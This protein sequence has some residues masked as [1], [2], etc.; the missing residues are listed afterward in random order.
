[1]AAKYEPLKRHRRATPNS[2]SEV[3]LSFQQINEII[4]DP[5]PQSAYTYREWWSNQSDTRNRPQAHAW[6]AAGFVVDA[7]HQDKP[8]ARVRFRRK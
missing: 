3:T 5:L 2:T 4:G 7:V 8:R 1:M 6:I